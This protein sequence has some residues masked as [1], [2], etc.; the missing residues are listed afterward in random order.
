MVLREQMVRLHFHGPWP[1]QLLP[2]LT[3]SADIGMDQMKPILDVAFSKNWTTP[4]E[5]YIDSQQCQGKNGS[6]SFDVKD[7]SLSCAVSAHLLNA[8]S[9]D[10]PR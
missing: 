3:L 2:I 5:L 9:L 4:H 6:E 8:P 7:L 1:T 10:L